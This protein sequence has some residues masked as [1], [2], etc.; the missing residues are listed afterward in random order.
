[1]ARPEKNN[2]RSV[3]VPAVVQTLVCRLKAIHGTELNLAQ[4]TLDRC[5]DLILY[6]KQG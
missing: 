4:G 1:M 2:V 6:L 5:G 3:L